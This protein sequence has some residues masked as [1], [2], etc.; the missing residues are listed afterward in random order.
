MIEKKEKKGEITIYYVKKDYD[1]N[2]LLKV[3]NKKLKCFLNK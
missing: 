3:L 1:D 2:K